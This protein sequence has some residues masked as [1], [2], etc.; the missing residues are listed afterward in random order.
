M[1][2]LISLIF[3]GSILA[4]ICS[5]LLAD[6]PSEHL[7]LDQNWKFYLGD[8]WP[9]A[10]H[11]N[12]AGI[13]GGP[14]SKGFDDESWR[15][16][17]L[18]HDWAIELPFDPSA[19]VNH[20]FRAVGNH[21]P[22][23]SIAWYRRTFELP[24]A[25]S[26]KRIWLQFDGVSRDATLFV[27]GWFV[28]HAESGYYPFRADI[29]D[30][31]QFGAKN[32][33][34]V[35]VDDSKFEGWFYEG[36]GIYRH[37]WLEI[38]NPVA[39]A[40]DGVFVYSKF[41]ENLPAGDANLYATVNI[42]NSTGSAVDAN[43]TYSFTDS[44]G[45]KIGEIKD[46]AHVGA[47]SHKEVSSEESGL[48]CAL[49]KYDLWSPETPRLYHMTTTVEVGG[50]IVDQQ[51]TPFGIRTIAFDK[52]K[53]FLLNG[54]P[55]ELYG[56]CNHQDHAGVGVALPDA[57]QYF[58][59]SK[60]KEI[61]CN[62]YR[63]SHN[64]PTPELLDACDQ[65]GMIVMDENR[66]LGSDEE[67]MARW[68]TEIRRDR[69]HPSVCIW[70]IC[71]EE[72]T[73]TQPVSGK[74]GASMQA[75]VKSLDPMRPVTAA[76]S[77]GDNFVGLQGTLE[78]RG[79]NYNWGDAMENYHK[80]HPDQPSVGTEQG[81]NRETRGIYET[82]SKRG[83][84]SSMQTGMEKWWQFFATRP[85][86]SGA[87]YWTGFDYRGEPSPYRWPCISSHF[88][89]LDTCGFPKDDAYYFKSCWSMTPQLHLLPHWNWAGKEGQE[90]PV[91]AFSNC[92]EVELF[93]NG[94]TQGKQTMQPNSH[95]EWKVKYAPGTLSATGYKA[96]KVAV[97]SKV[98][99]TGAPS[100]IQLTPDRT[101][102]KADGEDLSLISVSVTDDQGRVVPI[103][104]NLIHF[105]LSGPGKIIGVG[106]GDP[107]CHEPDTFVTQP[108]IKSIPISG[109]KWTIAPLA[110]KGEA[111]P[112]VAL[113]IDESNWNELQPKTGTPAQELHEG[114]TA[115]FRA[116]VTLTQE[117][118]ANPGLQIRFASLGD[119]GTVYVN[120]DRIDRFSDWG[121][122]SP[123]E[124]KKQLHAGDN[125]IAVWLSK[126]SSQG[127]LD[128][129]VQ[130][131]IISAPTTGDWSRSVFNGLAQVIVQSTTNP[132]EIKLT[133]TGDGLKTGVVSV[134]T[135]PATP[136]P[137]SLP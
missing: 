130:L 63:T 108:S 84:L 45:I 92:D 111:Q 107:S 43:I 54:K 32:I 95:L 128:P 50:A 100:T 125:V 57:L 80:E 61:G 13:N 20:G 46:K 40:P 93:L 2:Y 6:S 120:G 9:N 91:E 34:A 24:E 11:L 5:P 119:F 56:T 35:K 17:N 44:A 12:K 81:S 27:N 42:D 117:D 103:A 66:L 21:F 55:Y 96:G 79:W 72:S 3:F 123:F 4:S 101:S 67:N 73:Q 18:P 59:I 83:Y 134:K 124:A 1:K 41:K 86:L 74:V 132:E 102:I 78:V 110:K 70:S 127:G 88:G 112:E 82:D 71:N 105:S 113:N 131:E 122:P 16:I 65:L 77:T 15:T 33:I 8:D 64:P 7:S 126:D 38:K 98:D 47:L 116:H 76:E 75:L 99:T 129:H 135:T 26:N 87:F 62:A 69:N 68:E 121:P 36:A 51:E 58:R 137:T 90:I 136:R 37:T 19:D 31:V 30:L 94:Q 28:K 23:N 29:T 10:L 49:E 60:L 39:I 106:N 97:E 14:A 52:D 89:L 133:A 104:S 53:G 25:D 109:W 118:L 48:S 22:Q 115:V 114:E 85:W